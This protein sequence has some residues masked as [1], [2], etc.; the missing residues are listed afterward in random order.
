MTATIVF[1]PCSADLY[2][3]L[4]NKASNMSDETLTD[5]HIYFFGPGK[6]EGNS[7]MKNLL[8]GKG[9][10][11]AEMSRIGIPV[12]PGV[13]LTTELCNFYHEK[14]RDELVNRI[15]EELADAIA[16]LEDVMGTRFGD[17]ENPLL[18]SV[19]SGA[20]ASMPGMMD[21]VLNLGLNDA[22]VKGLAKRSGKERF[23]WDSYR[24]FIQMFADVVMH[25]N[26]NSDHGRD[27][28]EDILD[29]MKRERG[30]A[31]D[32]DLTVEDL[33]ELVE[34][35]KKAVVRLTGREFPMNPWDQLW[36]AVIAVFKSWF[37]P[38]ARLYRKLH[39][40]PEEWGTAVNV[41]AMVFGNM[42]A[43]SGSGVAFTRDPAT[44]EN[45]F[46][47]E[48]L[49]DAQGED[50][51]A[52]IRT[53]KQ[54]TLKG[55]K[56][57]AESA[58]IDEAT[59]RQEY[60]SLEEMH[61]DVYAELDR[62][63]HQLED[64]YRDMQDLE[65]TIQEGRLWILQTR[66][67]K[68][69]GRAMIRIGMEMYRDGLIDRDTLLTRMEVPKL[70][71]LLHPVFD[72]GSINGQQPICHGLPASPG[73]SSGRI[74]FSSD[75]ALQWSEEGRDVIL[76]RTETSA[77][78]LKG[79]NA[80]RGVLTARG[81]MTSHAAVVARG[82]GKCCVSGV[83]EL[84]IDYDEQT[85]TVD[86]EIFR[87]GDW[88]SLN[89]T[90]GDV[91]KG[92]LKTTDPVLEDDFRELLNIS[93]KVATLT[94]KTNAD[95]PETAR[96]A[97]SFGANG[98]GLCRTEH[99]FFEDGRIRKM[100]E[101]IM[102]DT[103]KE[104]RAA[105]A[106]LLPMQRSDFR[107]IFLAMEGSPVTIRLMDP[108]LHEFVPHEVDLQQEIAD[109]LGISLDAVQAKAEKLQEVN[110]MMGHRGCRLGIS[111]P[112]ITE[113]QTRAILEAAVELKQEGHDVRPE[114]MVPLV[115]T[116][117]EFTLQK[118]TIT[119]EADRVFEELGT[120]VDYKVG[121]M[122]EIPRA[123]LIAHQIAFR[124]EFFSFGTNDLTQMTFGYSRD[125]IAK[126]LPEYLEKGV[127]RY[128]PFQV[129]DR[130]GVGQLM[131]L[132]VSNGRKANPGLPIGICGEHGGEERS[133]AFCQEI[134][135]NYVSCSP[136]RV[137]LARLAAAKASIAAAKT[138]NEKD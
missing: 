7:E 62:L 125:D 95:T 76:V 123:A 18:V 11:L 55:S 44:G 53:P 90:T 86:G 43:A 3:R 26:E 54:I 131:R 60:P 28:L 82:M 134:G 87:K 78:D 85:M 83:G 48:F 110:P 114:I 22:S 71:E 66:T 56:R 41:Q 36:D 88:I 29:N 23:A 121:T 50:V 64:H 33:Q 128:D 63:Q 97:R 109:D 59:R 130:D 9:A 113:M 93:D 89:G 101:M 39:D 80:A 68:R 75:D 105:L 135:L 127:L 77:D 47:G 40:L 58:G 136:Y 112:E 72:S 1:S 98:I 132:C 96:L 115:G 24:R 67:G 65:F 119:D 99:M 5:R 124:A 116:L 52:G 27:A 20:R 94:V 4:L 102:A 92:K 30:A 111:Y 35:Y 31:T 69:T 6:S 138:K 104:R 73:A 129:I 21:T 25:V 103:E 2:T 17:P 79:M 42:G 45:L 106:E 57:W 126:F 91:F 34:K 8:G 74:V 51:V 15:R 14:G 100:R 70:D 32:Q 122:I 46:T 13:T 38:R 108:P 37:T 118:H 117:R 16:Y 81:G 120:T 107:E 133:I 137:P 61:P 84:D 10:N 19:R 12:P 49:M